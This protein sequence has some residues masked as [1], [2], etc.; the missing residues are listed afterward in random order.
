MV[1]LKYAQ[2][3]P[4]KEGAQAPR[5]KRGVC[6]QNR[7]QGSDVPRLLRPGPKRCHA[8]REPTPPGEATCSD[9]QC[10]LKSQPK[11]GLSLQTWEWRSLGRHSH[12][13]GHH[14]RPREDTPRGQDAAAAPGCPLGVLLCTAG[15][16]GQPKGGERQQHLRIT[17]TMAQRESGYRGSP[18][19]GRPRRLPGPVWCAE[20]NPKTALNSQRPHHLP[21]EGRLSQRPQ[22]LEPGGRRGLLQA[23]PAS[24]TKRGGAGPGDQAPPLHPPL[25]PSAAALGHVGM[26]GASADCS[27]QKSNWKEERQRLRARGPRGLKTASASLVAGAAAWAGWQHREGMR[28]WRRGLQGWAEAGLPP[29]KAGGGLPVCQGWACGLH[30]ARGKNVPSATRKR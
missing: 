28:R 26:E 18:G 3:M 7:P 5:L 20:R 14:T 2:K 15:E 10:Q 25:G 8:L 16:A 21:K 17:V 4:V 13:G 27:F 22:C 11:A 30:S 24:V 1:F 29:P 9:Q 23:I 19:S 12:S 6:T